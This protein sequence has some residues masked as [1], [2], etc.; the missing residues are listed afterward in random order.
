MGTT[1]VPFWGDAAEVR[2]N[3]V[4]LWPVACGQGP[5]RAV[6]GSGGLRRIRRMQAAAASSSQPATCH[7]MRA[8]IDQQ[9]H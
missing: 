4:Q 9:Q 8:G 6:I 5:G 3:T 2:R 7:A 1:G